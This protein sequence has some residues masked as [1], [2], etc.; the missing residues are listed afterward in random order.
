MW[1]L[2]LA[3]CTGSG[4]PA[5]VSEP[6]VVSHAV[7]PVP[8]PPRRSMEVVSLST[9][10]GVTL[11]ADMWPGDAGAPAV[12]L[13]HMTPKGGYHRKDWPS[14]L[15]SK[16]H[17]RRWWVLA[18]DRRGAG[19]SGGKAD[20]AFLGPGGR[21][22]VDSAMRWLEGQGV[23]RVAIVGA[24]NGTTS[25]IDYA[26]APT[27]GLPAVVGLGYL[28]GGTYTENQTALAS[29]PLLP[30]FFAY[31]ESEAEWSEKALATMPEASLVAR[32][33]FP[34]TDHGT[35]LFGTQP[36]LVGALEGWLA[37]VLD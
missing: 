11:Q 14:D 36:E 33:A 5:S 31:P 19:A 2:F 6:A 26:A 15:T 7:R 27:P 34:G 4:V 9:T 8:P 10:D 37:R 20:D 13:L 35:K 21:L 29:V 23:D 18:L 22:D 17:A 28:S 24:S 12:L 30:S 3:A 32:R 1:S 25:M 16:L